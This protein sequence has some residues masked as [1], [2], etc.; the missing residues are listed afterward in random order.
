MCRL[1]LLLT[2]P[3]R[4][5]RCSRGSKTRNRQ[6][7]YEAILLTAMRLCVIVFDRDGVQ[8]SRHVI[9]AHAAAGAGR[10]L[11]VFNLWSCGFV[12][13]VVLCRCVKFAWLLVSE[14]GHE[15]LTH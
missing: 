2:T 14:G 8:H 1:P 6:C 11:I 3:N 4:S 12:F 5:A 13:S 15:M 10:R 7:Y 9:D